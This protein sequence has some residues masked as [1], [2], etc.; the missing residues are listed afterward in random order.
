MTSGTDSG[1][2]LDDVFTSTI[3]GGVAVDNFN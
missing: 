3:D 1:N 2:A